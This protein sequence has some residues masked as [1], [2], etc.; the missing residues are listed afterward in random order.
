MANIHCIRCDAILGSNGKAVTHYLTAD[1]CPA[2]TMEISHE[3]AIEQCQYVFSGPTGWFFNDE[4]W[5]ATGPYE[6]Q[7]EAEYHFNRY[8]G[9]LGI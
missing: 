6:T 8:L 2:C 1:N 7:A 9:Y 3:L 4:T 5:E